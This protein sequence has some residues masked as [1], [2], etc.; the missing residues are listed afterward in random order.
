LELGLVD[1]LGTSDEYLVARA[2]EGNLYQVAFQRARS[3]RERLGSMATSA[4]DRSL[5]ALL[6]Q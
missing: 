2:A 4:I 1:Q 3:L 6:S 5:S